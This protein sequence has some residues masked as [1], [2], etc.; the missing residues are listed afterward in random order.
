MPNLSLV[1]GIVIGVSVVVL[2]AIFFHAGTI[3]RTQERFE[4]DY[5]EY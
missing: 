5:P 1:I 2:Y 4:R 3:N